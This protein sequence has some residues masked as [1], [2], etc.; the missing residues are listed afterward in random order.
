MFERQAKQLA[1]DIGPDKKKP[2]AF[3]QDNTKDAS[4]ASQ[5]SLRLDSPITSPEAQKCKSVSETFQGRI[6]SEKDPRTLS[7]DLPPRITLRF[8]SLH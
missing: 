6:L 7:A 5:E 8:A 4:R 3:H 1:E 2:G